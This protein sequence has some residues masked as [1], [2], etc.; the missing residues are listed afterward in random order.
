VALI[1][2]ITATE[3]NL[4]SLILLCK[5]MNISSVRLLPYH[6]LGKGKYAELGREYLMDDGVK[7]TD[8]EV[9]EIQKCLESNSITC[10]I[11]GL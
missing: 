5:E 8:G 4:S 7:I 2:G 9:R 10:I 6:T 11:E 3:K 1:P